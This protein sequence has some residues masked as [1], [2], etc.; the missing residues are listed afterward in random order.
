MR[1]ASTSLASFLLSTGLMLGTLVEARTF[2]PVGA[3]HGLD[4]RIVSTML[5]DSS[6]FLWVG[7][8]EG[9]YR[10]DGYQARLFQP[11]PANPQAVSDSDIRHVYEDS[12]GFIWVASAAGG[13]DRYDPSSG[14]FSRLRHDP[15]DATSLPEGVVTAVMDG[16]DDGLWVATSNALSRFDREAQSFVHYRH[17]PD[18]PGSLSDNRVISLHLSAAGRLW[19]GTYGG[20]VNLWSTSADSFTQFDLARLGGGAPQTNRA[21]SLHEDEEERLWVGTAEGLVRLSV[22]NGLVEIIDVGTQAGFPPAINAIAAESGR[23]WLGTRMRGVLILDRESGSWEAAS[24]QPLG[25]SGNLPT[26][27]LKSLVIGAGQVF[28]GTWGSG[29]YRSSTEEPGF[30]LLDMRIA[31]ELGNDVIS[32][33]MATPET[34]RPWVGTF[35]GGPRRVDVRDGTVSSMPL[36]RHG[37]RESGVMSLAGPIMSRIYAATAEGLYEFSQDGVQVS[38]YRH[39]PDVAGGLAEGQVTTLL[40]SGSTGL[41]VGMGGSG[42][43]YFDTVSLRFEHLRHDAGRV[44]SLSGDFVTALLAEGDT[45]L[46]V[47]THSAGLNRC[48]IADGSCERFV[49][50]AKASGGISHHHVTSIFRDR[51][52]RVWVGTD[53]GGLNRVVQEESGRVVEF[54]HWGREDGLLDNSVLAIQEDRDESLWLSLRDG[55]SR[56]N[57][58]TGEVRNFAASSGL[59]VSHFNV[60]ASAA[61]EEFIY[62]GSTNG[63]LSVRKGTLLRA[64]K[65]SRVRL[66]SVRHAQE[67]QEQAYVPT[68]VTSLRIPYGEMI[69]ITAAVLDYSEIEHEYAYRLHDEDAWIDVGTQGQMVFNSLAPGHY[70]FQARGRDA[71]GIWGESETFELDIIPPFWMTNWFKGLLFVLLLVVVIV[72]YRT[73]IAVLKRRANE[74]LRLGEKR[75]KALE[76]QLGGQSELAVLTPRQKEVLQL[77]AEG[78]ATREIAELLGV[79]VKTVEA[80]R[81]NLMERLEIHDVPGLV[82]LAI[83]SRLISLES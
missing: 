57:G 73:R 44:D 19:V 81:A 31:A 76:E 83:R 41:W 32:A 16:P 3:S 45:H 38:L 20:G 72:I 15:D 50:G 35:G 51:R 75:E 21:L 5:V 22:S 64:R 59:P 27:A 63:L 26:D 11:E 37:M 49:P 6:G 61:D 82:R 25:S 52:G 9:L 77:I 4:A 17:E 79:S 33:V 40:Q 29:V 69:S 66:T 80:H 8:R 53:G 12:R 14:T 67:G 48:A 55:M 28:A 74:K 39:D 47:G 70:E 2:T 7:S 78:N 68:G 10:F 42:L 13:L 23:L 18:D 36:K 34:G 65:P 46:W 71:N 56:L 54:L 30:S 58:A 1:V 24:E 62:F 43:H 60:N